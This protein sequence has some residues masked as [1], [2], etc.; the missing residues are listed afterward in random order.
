[1]NRTN[2]AEDAKERKRRKINFSRKADPLESD[3]GR[4]PALRVCTRRLRVSGGFLRALRYLFGFAF[5]GT[6]FKPAATPHPPTSAPH[7]A[8]RVALHT[9]LHAYAPAPA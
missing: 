6:G 5:L 8:R 4:G 7:P 1:M 3:C 2:D 9:R